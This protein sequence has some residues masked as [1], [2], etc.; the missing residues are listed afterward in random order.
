MPIVEYDREFGGLH[1]LLFEN[2]LLGRFELEVGLSTSAIK[3]NLLG[4]D[5]FNLF[6]IGFREHHQMVLL[7]ASP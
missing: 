5:F 4:R 2:E 7:K 6:Q 3:R 1:N